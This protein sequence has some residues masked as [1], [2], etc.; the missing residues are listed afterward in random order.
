M[1]RE[2]KTVGRIIKETRK[3][4]GMT[5]MELSEI[6]GVSYQQIQK[7]EKGL[8]TISVV[9]LKQIAK[10]LDVPITLFFPSDKD[11][12]AEAAATYGKMTDDEYLLLQLFKGIKDKNVKNAILEFLKA[13]TTS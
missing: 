2:A 10:A 6:V 5:Q 13:L 1:K 12:V 4:K 9:R 11:A 8:D 3:T 7:Y